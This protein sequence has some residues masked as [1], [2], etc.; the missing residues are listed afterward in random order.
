ME[1]ITSALLTKT[2][3]KLIEMFSSFLFMK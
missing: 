2:T 3:A 1:T